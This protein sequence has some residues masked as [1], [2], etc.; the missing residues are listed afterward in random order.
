M[1]I[2]NLLLLYALGEITKDELV[3]VLR[4][5]GFSSVIVNVLFVKAEHKK[6]LV[7]RGAMS[8]DDINKL[9]LETGEYLSACLSPSG[10]LG[11][12]QAVYSVERLRDLYAALQ[13]PEQIDG[14]KQAK[15]DQLLG[16][17]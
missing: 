9:W 6:G 2:N 8:Q 3:Q 16:G 13:K 15:S 10:S 11:E 4:E 1:N 7:Q 12:G 14:W 17:E 5:I